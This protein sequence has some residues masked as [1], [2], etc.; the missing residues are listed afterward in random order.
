MPEF[1]KTRPFM[2]SSEDGPFTIVGVPLD[3]T[4]SYRPGTRFGP[5]AIREASY[6]LEE[7]DILGGRDLREIRFSD[8]GDLVISGSPEKA[9]SQIREA[10]EYLLKKG[11]RPI[12]LGG[13][14]L[15]TFP[16]I[17]VMRRNIEDLHVIILD[18]HADMMDEYNGLKLSHATT[19]RRIS[20]VISP[21]RIF[22]F[23]IR[24]ASKEE[25]EYYKTTGI[26]YSLDFP[27]DDFFETLRGKDVYLSI[28]IDVLDPAFAPGTGTPEPCGWGPKEVISFL[29]RLK[30]IRLSG[31]D[32]VEVSPPFDP[33]G[34]TSI[35]AARLIREI[36]LY[37]T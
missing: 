20:E 11:Q 13:E 28:D 5:S 26:F 6:G 34:I 32:I 4:T 30:G 22:Q 7:Y 12:I 27:E 3:I 15:L 10:I 36:L 23:G 29:K 9:T 37:L 25:A 17:D 2:A 24:S 35:L 19:A 14:H 1:E 8:S 31:A 16:V 21:K 18:A 33:S